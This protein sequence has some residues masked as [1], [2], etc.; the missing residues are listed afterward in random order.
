MFVYKILNKVNGKIYIGKTTN[1]NLHRGQRK[2][3]IEGR[4]KGHTLSLET[5]LK[6]SETLKR[7]GIR[8]STDACSLGG[9]TTQG[10]R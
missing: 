10:A 3:A 1:S 9:K 5:R 7:K 8:P 6:I 4:F 2:R